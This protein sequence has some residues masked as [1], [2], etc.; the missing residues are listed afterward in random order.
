MNTILDIIAK[1]ILSN[2][3]IGAGAASVKYSFESCVPEALQKIH[4]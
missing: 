3:M 4:K 1:Y 2:A